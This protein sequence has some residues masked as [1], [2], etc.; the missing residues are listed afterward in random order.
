[1]NSLRRRGGG[2]GLAGCLW[3]VVASRSQRLLGDDLL[4]AQH[5]YAGSARERRWF[6]GL[7]CYRA[8]SRT[9]IQMTIPSAIVVGGGLAGMVIARELALRRWRV[10]LLEGSKRL[11]GKGGPVIKKGRPR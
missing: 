10:I 11:G 3:R 4:N 9:G 6:W 1:F 8:V 5:G 7:Q 2:S